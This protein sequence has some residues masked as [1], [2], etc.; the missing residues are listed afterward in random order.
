MV[1]PAVL[2]QQVWPNFSYWQAPIHRLLSF[3]VLEPKA[4]SVYLRKG[5]K[6][7]IHSPSI[8]GGKGAELMR[9]G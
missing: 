7:L 8:P 1:V 4:Q 2:I 6:T 9:S 3:G 5:V